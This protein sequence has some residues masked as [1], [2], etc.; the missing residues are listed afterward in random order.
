MIFKNNQP[1]SLCFIL[2]LL[3]KVCTD[4]ELEL[5]DLREERSNYNSNF[6]MLKERI[7]Y[8]EEQRASDGT[9]I[10]ELRNGRDRVS[11]LLYRRKNNIVLS[12]SIILNYPYH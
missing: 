11:I 6:D 5:N 2:Y 4:I 9:L 10:D 8:L 12:R 1:L 3:P 7:A